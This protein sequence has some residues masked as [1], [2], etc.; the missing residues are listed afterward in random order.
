MHPREPEG[1]LALAACRSAARTSAPW[2][3][4]ASQSGQ[5]GPEP[6]ASVIVCDSQARV[7]RVPRAEALRR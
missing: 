4:P 6:A 5:A 1:A 7:W 2:S 3:V